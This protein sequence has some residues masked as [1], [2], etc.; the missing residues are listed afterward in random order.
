[1]S[2]MNGK[3]RAGSGERAGANEFNGQ[4]A[5]FDHLT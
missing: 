5:N 1:M 3:S 2:D 4:D